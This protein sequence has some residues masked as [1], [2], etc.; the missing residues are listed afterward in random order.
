VLPK[1]I[2]TG[3]IDDSKHT[4]IVTTVSKDTAAKHEEHKATVND[5]KHENNMNRVVKGVGFWSMAGILLG[6]LL[7]IVFL[8]L[9]KKKSVLSNL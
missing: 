9:R 2:K 3:T 4:S 5:L 1:S 8:Y 7:F 6:C